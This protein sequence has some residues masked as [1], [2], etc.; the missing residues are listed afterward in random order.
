MSQEPVTPD[1][2]FAA[3]GDPTRIAILRALFEDPHEPTAFSDLRRAVGVRDSGQFNYHLG[4]LVVDRRASVVE[5]ADA[6][7]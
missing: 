7:E 6:S 2:A 5:T 1:E 3:L 4:E